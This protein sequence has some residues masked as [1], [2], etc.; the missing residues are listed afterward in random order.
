MIEP[1]VVL[2]V[3][4][5]DRT[6]E[7]FADFVGRNRIPGIN[8]VKHPAID[9]QSI[10]RQDLINLGV[11]SPDLI[12]I[13]TA[14]ACALS[15]MQCWQLAV[16]TGQTVLVCEDDAVL[17]RD[18]VGLYRNFIHQVPNVDLLYWGFNLDMHV[19]YLVPGFG[20]VL[21]IFRE[22]HF[23]DQANVAQFQ[24]S[25]FNVNMHRL[26]RIF[27]ALCY[28]ISPKCAAFL[29][30]ECLPMVND[31]GGFTMPNGVGQR[32]SYEFHSWGID[33][34]MGMFK[35]QNLESYVVV[36]PIVISPND[37]TVST[38]GDGLRTI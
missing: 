20:E 28:S 14:V 3:I 4:S 26:T 32:E 34:H 27:G 13:D 35:V 30:A 29:L 15:H 19:G 37:K 24:T 16:E 38:I 18:F 36:P 33:M 7:R 31:S 23:A 22:S 1:D 25:T 17:H 8:I 11:I 2:H 6:P 12:F 10:D 21:T 9:G 5:L